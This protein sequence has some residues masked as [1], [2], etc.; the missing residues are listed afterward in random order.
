MR[1]QLALRLEKVGAVEATF[2][3]NFLT[4]RDECNVLMLN[5]RG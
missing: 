1:K 4:S 3:V 5:Q 2:Q